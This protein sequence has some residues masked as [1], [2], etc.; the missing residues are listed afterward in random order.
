M[1]EKAFEC[2]HADSPEK[3]ANGQYIKRWQLNLKG[4]GN[5]Y[6]LGP[7]HD[8]LEDEGSFPFVRDRALDPQMRRYAIHNFAKA[9]MQQINFQSEDS[10]CYSRC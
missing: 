7:L 4:G 5:S 6:W 8:I 9:C 1:R 10:R 3:D 2:L